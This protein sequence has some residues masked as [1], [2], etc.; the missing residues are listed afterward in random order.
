LLNLTSGRL[1]DWWEYS[2]SIWSWIDGSNATGSSIYYNNQVSKATPGA[3]SNF[4]MTY[5]PICKNWWLF[6]GVWAQGVSS[7]TKNDLWKYSNGLWTWVSGSNLTNQRI[8]YNSPGSRTDP[9]MAIDSAKSLWI[10]GGFGPDISGS[11][12]IIFY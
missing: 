9:M 3:R 7:E 8:A 11:A 5:D 10:F 2:S 6:G 12:G 4:G 1:N